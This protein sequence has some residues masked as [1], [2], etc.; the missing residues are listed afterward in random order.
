MTSEIDTYRVAK[1]YIERY[2]DLARI[3]A[4]AMADQMLEKG[5]I[6][7]QR[8]WMRIRAAIIALTE[9]GDGKAN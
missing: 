7:G 1:L 6:A 9:P 2:G 4:A 8:T 5:D 3:E